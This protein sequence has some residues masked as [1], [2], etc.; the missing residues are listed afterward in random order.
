MKREDEDPLRAPRPPVLSKQTTDPNA[1][2]GRSDI[3][4]PEHALVALLCTGMG[5]EAG[6]ADQIGS[7]KCAEHRIALK[8]LGEPLERLGALRLKGRGEALRAHRKRFQ[9]NRPVS[10]G[11]SFFQAANR[12]HLV[13]HRLRPVALPRVLGKGMPL[14]RYRRHPCRRRAASAIVSVAPA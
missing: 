13:G 10:L 1:A 5:E 2:R 7:A 9:P 12:N 14:V 4:S 3:H 8:A 11:V 6:D